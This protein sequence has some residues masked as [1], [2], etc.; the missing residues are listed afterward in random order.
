MVGASQWNSEGSTWR[1]EGIGLKKPTL[2][3]YS[4]SYDS[5]MEPRVT[6]YSGISI[7]LS[8]SGKSLTTFLTSLWLCWEICA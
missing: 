1:M 4:S 5:L 7:C 6:Q 3:D 8:L 2:K